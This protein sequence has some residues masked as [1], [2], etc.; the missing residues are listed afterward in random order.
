MLFCSLAGAVALCV[1]RAEASVE[2]D[3]RICAKRSAMHISRAL[4]RETFCKP[5]MKRVGQMEQEMTW[6]AVSIASRRGWREVGKV[7]DGSIVVR[8][9]R[10][11]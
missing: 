4:R 3:L 5:V 6:D 9:E 8:L 10:V 2:T 1:S 11:K 7:K